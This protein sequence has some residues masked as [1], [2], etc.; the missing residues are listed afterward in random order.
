MCCI[1]TNHSE[2]SIWTI[3]L[4]KCFF[5]NFNPKNMTNIG[6]TIAKRTQ[7]S[8][9]DAGTLF[10]LKFSEKPDLEKQLFWQKNYITCSILLGPK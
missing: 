10:N 4:K 7:L 6:S 5:T 1:K 3:F 2:V 9:P 8:H